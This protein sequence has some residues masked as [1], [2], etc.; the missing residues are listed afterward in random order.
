MRDASCS[1]D[2]IVAAFQDLTKRLSERR[3]SLWDAYHEATSLMTRR[4]YDVTEPECW[5]VLHAG[6]AGIDAE[7]RVLER[8]YRRRLASLDEH[9]EVAV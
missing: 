2:D 3:R 5:S 6:L 8:E 9:E 7:E 1:H 4:E